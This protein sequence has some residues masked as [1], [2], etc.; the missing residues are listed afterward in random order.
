MFAVSQ[1][2]VGHLRWYHFAGRE[3]QVGYVGVFFLGWRVV[4]SMSRHQSQS[5]DP[6]VRSYIPGIEL[7]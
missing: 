4:R 2:A 6:G 1:H 7:V 3:V 5:N